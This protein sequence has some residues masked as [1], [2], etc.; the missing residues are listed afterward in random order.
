[1]H[2]YRLSPDELSNLTWLSEETKLCFFGDPNLRQRLSPVSRSEFGSPEVTEIIRDLTL[3][4]KRYRTRTGMGRGVA[5]NQ[6][7]YNKRIFV[8]W[9]WDDAQ[10]ITYINPKIISKR[11]KAEYM[12]SCISSGGLIVGNVI[13]PHL[14][15]IRYQDETGASKNEDL[16]EKE[17]RVFQH[18]LDHLNGILCA[19]HYQK[20]TVSFIFDRDQAKKFKLRVVS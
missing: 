18:E 19:D 14:I 13:R 12:E 17:S 2:N 3:F 9:D 16:N 4:L 11:N 20:G 5:A 10:P 7:G 15:T 8:V 6:L 1:M